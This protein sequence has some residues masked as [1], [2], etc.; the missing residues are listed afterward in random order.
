MTFFVNYVIQRNKPDNGYLDIG[1]LKQELE[2]IKRLKFTSSNNDSFVFNRIFQFTD[3]SNFYIDNFKLD[4]IIQN[5]RNGVRILLDRLIRDLTNNQSYYDLPTIPINTLYFQ[6]YG[7]IELSVGKL[8]N[9]DLENLRKTH[10]V[11]DLTNLIKISVNT[12]DIPKNKI[13]ATWLESILN[14]F[15]ASLPSSPYT[16]I[17]DSS[18]Y[19]Y[20]YNHAEFRYYEMGF[21]IPHVRFINKNLEQVTESIEYYK[22]PN[23][24]KPIWS[25]S[26]PSGTDYSAVK[27]YFKDFFDTVER[28]KPGYASYSIGQEFLRS[29]K[30]F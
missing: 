26:T 13:N 23:L 22:L 10:H 21:E 20:P 28:F 25:G 27:Y 29:L 30:F 8:S 19:S 3:R 1:N 14:R 17:L 11:Y 18:F 6:L 4:I 15:V 7:S 9:L 12:R 5:D 2:Q 16:T 24:P